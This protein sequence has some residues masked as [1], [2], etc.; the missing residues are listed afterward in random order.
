MFLE[1]HRLFGARVPR[2]RHGHL[3]HPR[4]ERNGLS[5]QRRRDALAVD[6]HLRAGRARG[7]DLHG[8]LGHARLDL[9][10]L[11]LGL[12]DG[13]LESGRRAR[14]E[15]GTDDRAVRLGRLHQAPDRGL[16]LGDAEH[17]RRR[18]E[19]LLRTLELVERLGELSFALQVVAFL[20]ELPRGSSLCVGDLGEGRRA[21]QGGRAEGHEQ[22]ELSHGHPQ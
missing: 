11:G 13:G 12:V 16:A 6:L 9:R 4:I 17:V 22:D 20:E 2:G 5:E 7:L 19:D 15:L 3:V 10:Q 8:Q 18:G 21:G 14:G 1:H